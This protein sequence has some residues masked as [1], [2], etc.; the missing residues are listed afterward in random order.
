MRSKFPGYFKPTQKQIETTWNNA[1]FVLDT[2]ILL[3]IYRYSTDTQDE[4]LKILEKAKSNLF[5]PHHIAKEFLE[6]RLDVIGQ[7]ASTYE[8]AIKNLNNIVATFESEKQHPF[9][10]KKS[11]SSL[12]S[13][14]AKVN[15]ELTNNKQRLS[16]HAND[17]PILL[18]ISSICEGKVGEEFTAQ[19]LDKH[20]KEAEKR[21]SLSIPPGYKDKDKSKEGNPYRPY[22]DY[23]IWKQVQIAAKTTNKNVL[24]VTDDQKEDWWTTFRGMTIHARPEL[25]KEFIDETNQSILFYPSDRFFELAG[26]FFMGKVTKSAIREIR[27]VRKENANVKEFNHR[28]PNF[29]LNEKA[30]HLLSEIAQVNDKIAIINLD[31]NKME[32]KLG[33]DATNHA[34]YTV[35]QN[36]LKRLNR[37]AFFLQ[38]KLDLLRKNRE[39]A[40]FD[41]KSVFIDFKVTDPSDIQFNDRGQMGLF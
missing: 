31:I 32:K 8:N 14:I 18:R 12:K 7:Q 16:D 2:N 28:Y 29:I 24:L 23:F 41:D 38:R 3:N 19:D 5:I 20:A 11:L 15:E 40:D 10:S 6:N 22:G 27:D 25:V 39:D 4:V 30:K 26:K 1:L 34:V 35:R 17:D 13:L 33:D 36:E 9:I 21:Y 37:K